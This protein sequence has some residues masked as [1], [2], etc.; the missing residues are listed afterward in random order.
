M[1][2]WFKHTW[3]CEI[4]HYNKLF[5]VPKQYLFY[6]DNGKSIR[7]RWHLGPGKLFFTSYVLLDPDFMWPLKTSC[8]CSIWT[9]LRLMQHINTCSAF[10]ENVI[11][12]FKSLI[13]LEKHCLFLLIYIFFGHIL[14][15]SCK[16][17]L[18]ICFFF[19]LWLMWME[20][21]LHTDFESYEIVVFILLNIFFYSN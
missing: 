13:G 6:I 12:L 3:Y 2:L 4:V 21:N 15:L 16:L 1:C 17:E 18:F 11:L 7:E 10:I 8:I 9:W 5:F 19:F 14:I 20:V